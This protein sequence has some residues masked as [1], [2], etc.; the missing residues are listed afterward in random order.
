[1]TEK[2]LQHKHCSICSKAIP[3]DEPFCSDE[4]KEKWDAMMKKRKMM[5]YIM[6]GMIAVF[7]VLILFTSR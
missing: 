6:Y 1:M 3:V 7:I 5:M 2:I 4:C